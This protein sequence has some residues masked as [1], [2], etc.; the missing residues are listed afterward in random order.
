MTPLHFREWQAYYARNPFGDRRR[1]LRH[2]LL[3]VTLAAALGDATAINT[4]ALFPFPL[5]EE[6]DDDEDDERNVITGD[7]LRHRFQC[8]PHRSA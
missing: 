2:A 6:D 5:A 3:T 7:Q 1:D 4:E 8:S